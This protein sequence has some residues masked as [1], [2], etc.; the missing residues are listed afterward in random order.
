MCAEKRDAHVGHQGVLR[1]K[2]AD[3]KKAA[4]LAAF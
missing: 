3:V 4:N 2:A 1:W